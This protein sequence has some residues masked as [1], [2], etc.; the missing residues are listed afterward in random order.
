MRKLVRIRV[1]FISQEGGGKMSAKLL[2]G[3]L[4]AEKIKEG[5]KEEVEEFKKKGRSP[6]LVAVQVGENPASRIYLKQQSKACS[7]LG[8]NYELKHL[9]EQVSQEELLAFIERLNQDEDICGIILQ[10]PLPSYLDSRAAQIKISPRKDVEGIHPLNMGKLLYGDNRISPPTPQAV[11]ELLKSTQEEL[12]GKETV[13]VGHSEIV[14]KPLALLLLQSQLSSPTV[15]V[16]HIATRD[17]AFHTKRADILIVAVG[18][19]DLIRADMLKEGVIVIDVGINRVSILDGEGKPVLDEKGKP[20]TRIVGD[21]EFEEAVKIASY[22]TP[23][24]GGV[25]PLTTAFLLKNT[26]ECARQ[27]WGF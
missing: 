18:K 21:V 12:K 20:E 22:I 23:V 5:L 13:I 19:P 1:K 8:I 26:V 24:P 11:V 9:K 16:C 6:F 15:T 17:L 14:G 10:M 4:L 27:C 7:E 2:E 25:G 3:R